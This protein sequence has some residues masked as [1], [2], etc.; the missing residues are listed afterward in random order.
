MIVRDNA[1]TIRA[2]LESIKPWVDE[3]IVVDTG[4]TDATPDICRELGAR[5]FHFP[6]PD[7]FA[8]ARNESLKHARQ[9]FPLSQESP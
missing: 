5:V 9:R 7:S 8:I 3:M 2:C 1:S 6:W 4:S